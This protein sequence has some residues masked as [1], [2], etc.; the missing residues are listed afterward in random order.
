MKTDKSS[1][2]Q[3]Q[4]Y[5][6]IGEFWDTH[7][8]TNFWDTTEP[9]EFE[10]DIQSE[11][12]YYALDRKLVEDVG[13]IAWQRGIS[14]ETLLNLWVYEKVAEESLPLPTA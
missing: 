10:V 6:E 8:A 4:S 9:V 12:R 2:S 1:I 11:T 7:D 3:A 14:V 5:R 13:Q